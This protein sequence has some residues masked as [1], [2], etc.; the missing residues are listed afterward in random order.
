MLIDLINKERL[1]NGTGKKKISRLALNWLFKAFFAGLFIALE[2]FIY[3]ELDKKIQ[4]Y[5]SYGTFDFLVF[6]IFIMFIIAIVSSLFM[7]RKALFNKDDASIMLVLPVSNEEIIF[8]KIIFIYARQVLLSLIIA[9]PLLISYGA[10]RGFFPQYY[11]LSIIYPLFIS[12]GHN[13]RKVS[14]N[15]LVASSAIDTT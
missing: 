8:S 4:K 9:T 11:V 10:L 13:N 14:L 2:C 1:I 15:L 7:A 12:I 5:S 3:L 6:F